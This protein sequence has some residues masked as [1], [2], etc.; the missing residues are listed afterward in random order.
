[1]K[2]WRLG[3][4][5][6]G[7]S[8]L[9]LAVAAPAFAASN[10]T[11]LES[12]V[13]ASTERIGEH[14][15]TIA[16]T[17]SASSLDLFRGD[18]ASL[19]YTIRATDTGTVEKAWL[20]G[21]VTVRNAG[22]VTTENLT[23]TVVASTTGSSGSTLGGATVSTSANPQL[24]PGE[25]GTYAY[26]VQ[27]PVI[28]G[29]TYKATANV[30]ITNHSGALGVP[31]GPS[32]SATTT[33]T[34]TITDAN[35]S[36]NVDD[37]NGQSFAFSGTGTTSYPT[38]FSCDR[39]RGAHVNTATIRQTGA[40]AGATVTV[41]CHALSISPSAAPR[42]T[43]TY[44]WS[45]TKAADTASLTLEP[46]GRSTKSVGYTVG[47][48]S[49][50]VDSAWAV[51]GSVVVSNP[52]PI[53]ASLA[54]VTASL[55]GSEFGATCP[56]TSVPA[57]GSLTCT[58]DRGLAS[59]TDTTLTATATLTNSSPFTGSVAVVFGTV[60]PTEVDKS[61]TVVDRAGAATRSFG[62]IS[63]DGATPLTYTTT[64]GPYT[65][66]GNTT[67]TNTAT[68]TTSTTG[69]TKSAGVTIPVSVPCYR[70]TVTE[71][72]S[73]R[74]TRTFDWTI[75]KSAGASSLTLEP[76]ASGDLGYTVDV[77]ST[78]VDSGWAA[79]GTVALTNPAPVPARLSSLTASAVGSGT[80]L[81]GCPQTVNA[82]ET[83]AC[84]WSASLTSGANASLAV[85]AVLSDSSAF[86]DTSYSG[87]TSIDFAS[88]VVTPIDSSVR[89]TDVFGTS[90]RD[91]GT[92]NAGD[93]GR[94]TYA[95]T[96]GPYA[97][98]G[99]YA[100]ANSASFV[101][102]S[103]A[104]GSAATSTPVSVK[105]YD[106]GAST[107]VPAPAMTRTYGWSIAKKASSSSLALQAGAAGS[108]GYTVTL[109]ST[110]TD[111]GWR[112]SGTITITNPAPVAATLSGVTAGV[113]TT[114]AAVTCPSDLTVPAG[115]S[116]DCAWT[117]TLGSGAPASL[118]VTATLTD[119][120]AF[121][122]PTARATATIDFATAAITEIDK[123]ATV[124]DVMGTMTQ[125]FGPATAGASPTTY[126][127]TMP[128]GPFST[129]A[130]TTVTN[131]A[132]LTT[133]DTRTSALAT[134]TTPVAITCYRLGVSTD[135]RSELTR[136]Y[137]W[138]ITKSADRTGLTLEQ[139][140]VFS[141][142]YSVG[143][144]S[145]SADGGWTARGTITLRNPAPSA[146][147]LSG[148]TAS[149]AG[150]SATVGCPSLT[151]PGGGSLT[152]TWSRA[153]TA[154]SG[155]TVTVTA[156][157]ADAPAFDGTSYGGSASF[158]FTSPT[159]NE[160][161]RSVNVTDTAGSTTRTLGT[162]SVGSAGRFSYP[163]Q[164]GPYAQC[165]QY[166]FTNTATFRTPSGK[167]G[168]TTSTVAVNVPCSGCTLTI[169]YWKTHA[170]LGPQAD[171]MLGKLPVSLGTAGGAKTVTVTTEAQAVTILGLAGDASN[172]FNKLY[173][174]LL[175][176]KLNIAA[177]ASASSVATTI[178]QADKYLATHD[179]SDWSK[180]SKTDKSRV[181]SWA[182][183]LDK[184]NNGL[185]GPGHCTQ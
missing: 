63:A 126:G 76:A 142:N 128:V 134:V 145:A 146:V 50:S 177:G 183:T 29:A 170:G 13:T 93:A 36:I 20:V 59:R 26:R 141:V 64:V 85:T 38:T 51:A 49:S 53:P 182:S 92:V 139:G 112:V 84:T 185:I 4:A 65:K 67:F 44:S 2:G 46:D 8:L 25:I 11:T 155:G 33:M 54:G 113:G 184:Y 178:G 163:M 124:K 166:A 136:T 111:A 52:A 31:E 105:C 69:A 140:Q 135:A 153:L 43:R 58:Y 162:V 122:S 45:L 55:S 115:R 91:L 90:S 132:T 62:P 23:I 147:T 151:I 75:R 172:G 181:L 7:G 174:Q 60:Q 1:M 130:P 97:K 61:V 159:V 121:N 129:C 89:V 179:A 156:T 125:T 131:N 78:P 154:P 70:L 117:A 96:V 12:S 150:A 83:V 81:S 37:S 87:S 161:D 16:K 9:V 109:S 56:A 120:G 32:P 165:G 28:S 19:T 80:T 173:A 95:S 171:L 71:T 123:T 157:L 108:L 138:Q 104:T 57:G 168:S 66:C 47:L 180:L 114:A 116:I 103:G 15:W 74:L 14:Q 176:A 21:T 137:T 158:D 149:A 79:G 34:T 144:S 86:T 18:S 167:T 175:A 22:D 30:T 94:F 6:L 88:A 98:C 101:A 17:A 40:S 5:A 164:V 73:T 72:S 42:F 10:G 77:T 100:V 118:A 160:V 82:G 110:S 39:D 99:G 106:L 169:G 102:P 41:N 148:V 119:A 3:L 152:C 107:S 27:V 143:V 127:Y 48:G 24:D 68:L 133:S 35:A